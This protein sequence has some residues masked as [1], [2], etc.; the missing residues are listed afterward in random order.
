MVKKKKEDAKIHAEKNKTKLS[1]N[2][3]NG[4]NIKLYNYFNSNTNSI[5]REKAE[6]GN[7]IVVPSKDVVMEAKNS[8]KQLVKYNSKNSAKNSNNR[9]NNNNSSSNNH[10]DSRKSISPQEHNSNYYKS[11]K[12][13]SKKPITN[14]CTPSPVAF[15]HPMVKFASS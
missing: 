9:N 11:N 4:G 13:N 15:G 2:N 12:N 3:R 1:S 5:E 7:E 6:V 14:A 8:Y 10:S